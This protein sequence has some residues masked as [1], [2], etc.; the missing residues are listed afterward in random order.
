MKTLFIRAIWGMDLPSVDAG[1]DKIQQGGFDGVEMGVPADAA[2]RRALR[3]ALERTGLA[4]IAQQ[5]TAGRTPEEHVKSFEAQYRRAADMGPLF[6]NSHTGRDIFTLEQNLLVFRAA[7]HLEGEVGTRVLHETHRGRALYSAPATSVL[8]DALPGLRLTADFSHWCCVHESL[9]EDQEDTVQKAIDASGHIHARVGHAEG[10]QVTHPGAPEWK[11]AVAAHVGWWKRIASRHQREG[12]SQLT[13]CPE[14]GP[15][16]YM[17]T[18]P[19]TRQ[20]VAD[21]W[22]ITMYMK[23]FLNAHL[24]VS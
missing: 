2:E 4:F 3:L 13:V 8:L 6:V 24:N 15:V 12:A 19:W 18:L 23:D 11:D 22:E 16:P 5:W 20:P 7:A 9:L 10:P 14:F 21:L 17:P 1:L